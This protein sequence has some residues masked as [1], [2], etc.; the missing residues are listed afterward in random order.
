MPRGGIPTLTRERRPT[1]EAEMKSNLLPV[2]SGVFQP[3]TLSHVLSVALRQFLSGKDD[4]RVRLCRNRGTR[5]G[6]IWKAL[7]T[8]T[9][10]RRLLLGTSG[11]DVVF[12]GIITTHRD[13]RRSW[14]CPRSFLILLV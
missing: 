12:P 9:P 7:A 14:L 10:A 3:D 13:I 2:L 8:P 5:D 1:P 6:T 4:R 11:C